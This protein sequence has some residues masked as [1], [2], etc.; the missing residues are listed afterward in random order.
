MLLNDDKSHKKSYT[1]CTFMYWPS[2][3]YISG[4]KRFL[5]GTIQRTLF[6]I[7]TI[8]CIKVINWFLLLS[9]LMGA[10][11]EPDYFTIGFGLGSCFSVFN[12]LYCVLCIVSFFMMLSVN[13]QLFSFND[14]LILL[15]FIL[16]KR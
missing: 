5:N 10:N 2:L 9:I 6:N 3:L 1:Q 15:E 8:N 4:Q 16:S 7:N 11:V 14:L 13:P 12:F